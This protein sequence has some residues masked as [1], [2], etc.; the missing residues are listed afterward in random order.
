MAAQVFYQARPASDKDLYDSFHLLNIYVI[1]S[2]NDFL[3]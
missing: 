1:A 2:F 3:G